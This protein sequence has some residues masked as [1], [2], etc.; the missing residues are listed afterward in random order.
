MYCSH[1]VLTFTDLSEMVCNRINRFLLLH[2]AFLPLLSLQTVGQECDLEDYLIC[3][4]IPKE[5]IGTKIELRVGIVLERSTLPP[6][7]EENDIQTQALPVDCVNPNDRGREYFLTSSFSQQV[8]GQMEKIN[9]NPNIL[10]N[11]HL[12]ALLA[13]YL[14]DCPRLSS[15]DTHILFARHNA[16]VAVNML[17]DEELHSEHSHVMANFYP[18]LS[19]TSHFHELDDWV[20][21]AVE[22]FTEKLS[23]IGSDSHCVHIYDTVLEMM[24]RRKELLVSTSLFTKA[25][26][27][28]RIGL[29]VD[30]QYSSGEIIEQWSVG[31]ASFSFS[32]YEEGNFLESFQNFEGKEIFVYVFLGELQ[33]YLRFLQT[34]HSYGVVGMR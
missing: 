19:V 5:E 32:C 21:Q 18:V 2:L 20:S 30:C 33:S 13:F 29:V 14:T 4:G 3:P 10:A 16:F 1:I 23:A 25:M 27:W 7:P 11:H 12:C 8:A 31:N 22:A 34:A 17:Y 9:T 26:G 6:T 28:K 15:A 24:I